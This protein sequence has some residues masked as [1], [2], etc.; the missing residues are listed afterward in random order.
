MNK[1][2]A[3]IECISSIERKP[4]KT[5]QNLK[6]RSPREINNEASTSCSQVCHVRWSLLK[7]LRHFKYYTINGFWRGKV[8]KSKPVPFF[9]FQTGKKLIEII[10][11]IW[12]Q[13]PDARDSPSISTYFH[14]KEKKRLTTGSLSV[15]IDSFF[16]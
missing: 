3:V 1:S 6:V 10:R 9:F 12:Y 8:K 7:L 2:T 13:H 14:L 5:H 16:W 11:L 4:S 15:I